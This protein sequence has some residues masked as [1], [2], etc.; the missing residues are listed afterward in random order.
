MKVSVLVDVVERR[1][2]AKTLSYP[3]EIILSFVVWLK[4]CDRSDV[5]LAE[6][7]DL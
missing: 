3:S 2:K 7:A 1:E 6:I 5:P 4:E